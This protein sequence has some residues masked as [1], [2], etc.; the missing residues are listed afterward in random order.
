MTQIY[1][2][3]DIPLDKIYLDNNFNCRGPIP[4]IDVVSLAKDIERNTLLFPISLQPVKDA[5]GV[6]EGFDYRV[7][8]GHRRYVAFQILGRTTIPAMIRRGL[9]EL[10]ARILNLGENLKRQNLNLLQEAKALEKLKE[11]GL[12]QEGISLELGASRS[13]VQVRVNLLSL[14]EAIQNE[15]AAG[16]LNQNQIKQIYSLKTP[17]RQYEA[18]R[19]IKNSLASGIRGIDVGKQATEK[20][21][22]K[23][24]QSKFSLQEMTAYIGK[25]IGYG[26]TTRALAWANGEISTIDLHIDIKTEMESQGKVYVSPF[27]LEDLQ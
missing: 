5:V 6:P 18:V 17:E 3:Q 14:P 4:K 16:M 25:N 1:E 13:W 9:N 11:L 26:L 7:I 21:T 23:K 10:Q 2:V 15:A 12:T 19:K 20:P 27:K 8:A 24:R 22:Q